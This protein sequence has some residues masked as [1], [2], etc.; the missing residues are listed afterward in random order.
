MGVAALMLPE[1]KTGSS[2]LNAEATPSQS[3]SQ[4]SMRIKKTNSA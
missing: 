3:P 1:F 2:A 4:L